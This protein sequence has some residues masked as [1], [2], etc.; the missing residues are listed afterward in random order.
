MTKSS[1]R[2]VTSAVAITLEISPL[3]HFVV[4]RNGHQHGKLARIEIMSISGFDATERY[5]HP[6]RYLQIDLQSVH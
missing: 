3:D 5:I 1:K 6:T 2:N 4:Y